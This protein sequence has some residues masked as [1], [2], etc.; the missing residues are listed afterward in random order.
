[1]QSSNTTTSSGAIRR[2]RITASKRRRRYILSM[3]L[4]AM[5]A[6][7]LSGCTPS[8]YRLDADREAYC[9]VAERFHD[10]RWSVPSVS[11]EMD[12]RSRY[13]DAYDPDNSP[14]PMDDPAAHRYMHCVDGKKGWAHWDDNGIRPELE[15]EGWQA[16]L[17]DYTQ[18]ADDGAVRLT[19]DSAIQLAYMHSPAHQRTLETLYLSS[20]DVTAQ[21]FALDTQFFGGTATN[22]NHSGNLTPASIRFDTGLGRYVVG[23]PIQ[24]V[25]SNRLTVTNDIEARRRFATAGEV[26]VGFV[27][28]F[29]FEFTGTDVSLASSLLN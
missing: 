19:P 3:L 10:P 28:S 2:S 23:G 13:H 15:N 14:M 7:L 17:G 16:F 26:L 9:T 29:A 22:Y 5:S 24:G 11:I 1:M 12:P 18:I 6:P 21:R 8:Q 20:L 4:G 27:N 25:E